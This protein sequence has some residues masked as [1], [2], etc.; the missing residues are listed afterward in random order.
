MSR[1]ILH[2]RASDAIPIVRAM[3]TGGGGG[4]DPSRIGDFSSKTEN[5]QNYSFLASDRT[6]SKSKSFPF[7]APAYSNIRGEFSQMRINYRGCPSPS[8]LPSILLLWV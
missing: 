2:D 8:I 6:P 7:L 3:D 5:L 1:Q 4:G